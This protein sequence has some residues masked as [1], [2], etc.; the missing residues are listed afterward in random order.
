[1][2]E[3]VLTSIVDTVITNCRIATAIGV[4]KAGLAIDRGKIVAVARD[5]NLPRADVRI[6]ARGKIAMPG[7][8]DA[9][10]HIFIPGWIRENFETGTKA[11]AVGGV[12]TVIE[13]PSLDEWLTTTIENLQRKRRE[14]E[15]EALVDFA[16][17]GGE[18]QEEK[19]TL[20]IGDLVKEGV[21]GFKITMGGSTAVRN[22]GIMIDALRRIAEARSVAAVHAESQQLLN[23]FRKK[24][25]SEGG[26]DFAAYSDSRPNIVEAEAISRAILYS[27]EAGNR[28]HIAHMSTKEGVRLVKQA[29]SEGLRVTSET[30]PQFLLFTRDD[31]AK[32]GPYIVTNPPP[33]SKD[34]AS[35]LWRALTDGT[36]DIVATD[37]CAFRKEEKDAGWKNVLETPAG[38]PGLETLVPLMLSEG[39]NKGRIPLERLVKL[40]SEDPAKIFNLYPRKGTIQVGSDAD[41]VIVDLK[42][43]DAFDA[44]KL[45]CIADFTPFDG[46]RIRGW[47]LIT[48]VRGTIV[49]QEG[50]VTGKP[51]YGLFTPSA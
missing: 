24:V 3:V 4:F 45:R 6:D 41:I 12:T 33:R 39:V 23:Y 44:A 21:V 36:V 17:Y 19:D 46:W 42:K 32:H 43:E 47:P 8:I 10:T 9:H 16:L 29:K 28:L 13:M 49:A 7:A 40:T 27:K 38:I 2:S 20:E 51:G 15:K 22:D 50:E 30:C 5:V 37:H 35:G 31:Y 25:V 26:K 14:G 34:D 1:M 18:I 48:M 11:A